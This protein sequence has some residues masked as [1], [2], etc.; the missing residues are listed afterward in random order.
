[1]T[2]LNKLIVTTAA[3]A[4]LLASCDDEYGPRKESTPVIESAAVTPARFAFGDSVTLTARLSDPATTLASL[5]CEVTADGR[6]I[7]SS[8]LSVGGRQAD[9]AL[10]LFI[11]LVRNQADNVAV[12]VR[13]TVDNVLK[14]AASEEIT[15]LTGMRVRY[16]RLYLVTEGGDA[17]A[18]TP[19]ES[20]GDR[21]EARGLTLPRAFSYRIAAQVTDDGQVDYSR[22]V[23]GSVDGRIAMTGAGGEAAFACVD[24]ADDYVQSVVYD[25]YAFDLLL[26]GGAYSPNDIMPDAFA[27]ASFDGEA[28]RTLT[29][30][31]VKNAEYT[32]FGSLADAQLVYNPDFFER[33]AANKVRF[34][35]ETGVYT[36]Y[37]N[38]YRR[39]VIVGVE[40]PAY[41]HY[42]LVTG[43]G[44]G[45]PTLVEGIDREH[46]WWGFGN[47]RN[48]ILLRRIA[49]DVFQGTIFIHAK[50]DSWVG[51]KPYET[52]DWGG[53]KGF[54]LF[55]VTGDDVL[56]GTADGNWHPKDGLDAGAFYRLTIHWTANTVH[57][58][59]ITL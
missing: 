31:L 32:L 23:W 27:D 6:I 1:M 21:Y 51:F 44:I 19:Q 8:R 3:A 40:H 35:G 58:A 54:A 9:I 52:T 45:Y 4:L 38:T 59:K 22:A 7:A 42:L 33:P 37:H 39:H 53:E 14:G 36:L 30:S 47:V 34:L 25:N 18:L 50:D 10:P 56:E 48:F 20:D 24:G 57:V 26:S 16:D 43:G 49:D 28:F 29:R 11:P 41:P 46:A 15:G 17:F 5:T 13:I 12:T 55:T 2:A